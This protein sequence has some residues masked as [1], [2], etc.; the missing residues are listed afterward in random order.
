MAKRKQIQFD[1]G[2]PLSSLLQMDKRLYDDS[3]LIRLRVLLRFVSI[4]RVIDKAYFT[5][6]SV[7][8]SLLCGNSTCLRQKAVLFDDLGTFHRIANNNMNALASNSVYG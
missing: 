3:M 2:Y 6:T 7:T 8:F 1:V 5:Y 4:C